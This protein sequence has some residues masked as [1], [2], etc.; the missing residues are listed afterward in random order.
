MAYQRDGKP[1]DAL[2]TYFRLYD[3]AVVRAKD[4]KSYGSHQNRDTLTNNIDT[5]MVRMAQRGFIA[6]M[7]HRPLKGYDVDPPFDVGFS[8]KVTVIEER[9]LQIEGTWNVLPVGTRIRIVLKD[10]DYPHGVPAGM[11]WDFSKDVNLDPPRDK[12]FMQDQLFVK[13]RRFDHKIDM[14]KDPTMYPFTAQ[15]YEVEFYYNPRSAPPHIQDKF[16]WNG[17]G[18]TDKNFLNMDVRPGQRV[19]YYKMHLTRDQILR[20]GEWQDKVPV[21]KSPNFVDSTRTYD[22]QDTII[23]IPSLRSGK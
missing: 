5:T 13:N 18:M 15:D 7:E 10:V 3:D 2:N 1:I 11:V 19:V 6:E 16:S 17:E 23:D 8:V 12:T 21:V 20:R 9:K 4:D 14:S 22:K